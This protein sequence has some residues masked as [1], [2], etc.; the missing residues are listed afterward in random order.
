MRNTW[1]RSCHFDGLSPRSWYA[2]ANFRDLEIFCRITS[3]F[4]ITEL[5]ALSV[6]LSFINCWYPQRV[7]TIFRMS[8]NVT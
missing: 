2:C 8:L 7:N 1:P 3:C 6:T 5:T 4:P